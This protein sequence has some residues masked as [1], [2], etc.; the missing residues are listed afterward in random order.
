MSLPEEPGGVNEAGGSAPDLSASDAVRLAGE[1]WGV[2]GDARPLPSDRDQNFLVRA[3][4]GAFVLKVSRSGED[5]GLL[6]CQNE[7][8]A[9]VAGPLA[10][11]RV[12][13]VRTSVAGREI[14]RHDGPGG[15]HLV[16]LLEH[17]PGRPLAEANPR[18]LALLEGTGRLL[19]RLDAVLT[20]YAHPSARRTLDWDL[21]RGQEVAAAHLD[22]V[23]DGVRRGLVERH[24][25]RIHERVAPLLPDLRTGVIHGDG[26]DWN[27]L[28]SEPADPRVP[29][30]VTGLLDFGDLVDSWVV[31]EPAIA[32]AYA[33]LDRVDPVA[34]AAAVVR[35]Y[36]AANALTEPE[37]AAL[38]PLATLRLCVSVVMSARQRR[39]RPDNEYLSVSERAAWAMLELLERVNGDHAHYRLRDAC[40]WPACPA[41]PPVVDWL[42]SHPDAIGPVLDPDPASVG[43]L[44]LDLSVGSLE[45]SVLHG[46]DD[47][48][49]WTRAVFD[50]M[51]DAGATLGVGRY[52]E[53]RRW[54]TSEAFRT[55]TDGGPEWRTVHLGIDLFMP[56]GTPVLAPLDGTVVATR[57]NAGRLD[58]GPTILL[59]HQAGDAEF[60]T[61]YG[62]LAPDALELEAGRRV[63]RGERIAAIGAP[64]G[65]G[66]WAPHLHLQIITDLLGYEGTFPGV[67][68][69]SERAVWCSVSPDP[70][71]LL[72]LPEPGEAGGGG[73]RA[74]GR[75]APD[76]AAH[77]ILEARRRHIG[78]NL[79]I[80]YRRPLH[81][82]R[83]WM[84]HLYDA[85]GQA[86]LDCVNNVAH[87]G[88]E[89]PRVVDALARQA[90]VLNT[91]T[92]YLHENLVR[93]AER[94]TATLPEPLR[95][96]YLVNSGSEANELALRLA[97]T[98]TGRRD[99]VV[100]DVA[101]HGNT[102]AVIDISP[103]KFAGP[104]GTGAPPETHVAPLPDPYR[105][106]HRGEDT[107]ERYAE[108][109]REA[110]QA[111]QRRSGAEGGHA[112]VAAFFAESIPS[113]GGQVVL[114]DGFLDAAYRH[115]RAA[116]GVC[117]ADEV[118][119]GL[120][121]VGSHVWAFETQGVVPDIVTMG[122][123][124]GNGHPLAAV[125]TTPEIAASFDSG[126][127]YFNT[128][129][130]NPVSCAV[131]L[132]VLD[133]MEDE[134]LQARALR[135]GEHF[136]AG[137]RGLMDRHELI[138]NVRGLGLFLGVELVLDR[139]SREPATRHA[140]AV[141]DRM[142][143]H[144]I[145]LSTD[146][147]DENVLKIKPPLQF[148]EAD[149]DRVVAT[150]DRVLAEHAL[151]LHR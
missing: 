136:S 10:P 24:L 20:G 85:H 89:H 46:R 55:N 14:E 93:Y 66:D 47:S 138:G 84:Q 80:S 110:V 112:G 108:H 92:R 11:L 118:Q 36:H 26:N 148:S 70:N 68:R 37:V 94:L 97:R 149:A 67:A 131:G 78:P 50:R 104:G 79:S 140:A 114:P 95:V 111:A 41:T 8:L 121:R 33:M 147:P 139:E 49:A 144:G 103:Y 106:R 102:G 82:V 43:R 133:V 122:K 18:S 129:G 143:D 73:G 27:I 142:R 44:T 116:G 96:C 127:E 123:P 56:A 25:A 107:A 35:G 74:A 141:V 115:V 69:P 151:M 13:A 120:G 145:L 52:D 126:M 15:V 9:R 48:T 105:G 124:I 7:V 6:E 61:L 77:D 60:F 99:V 113:C 53:P 100:L 30:A 22:Q 62:H 4:D 39:R 119:T 32:A 3:P 98:H 75:T 65:N 28:V 72:R 86:Y 34:A 64:P 51:R 146:G 71:L 63:R 59:R 83:G 40:G 16:R 134:G 42:R 91:N 109:V 5:A 58:Y 132:A 128:F 150:L 31:A 101:Y 21:R 57:D 130:G 76:S 117:V 135:V 19:G 54:Y 90:A 87:V 29:A 81:I 12:P 2:R 88:H 45:W 17:V 125:V 23:S 1:L 137:L 38:F